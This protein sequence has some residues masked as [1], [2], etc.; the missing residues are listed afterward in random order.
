MQIK[1]SINSELGKG[2]IVLFVMMNIYFFFNFLFHFAM[3]RILGPTDYGT[4]A[5]LMS[6]IYI[7]SIP[8][9]AIQNLISSYV[10]KLN[11]KGE[12]GKIKY[13][14]KNIMRYVIMNSTLT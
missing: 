1:K 14:M 5:V 6:F 7:Y 3:G 8:S 10:S 4:F 9:E 2:T 12:E 11:V 13:L